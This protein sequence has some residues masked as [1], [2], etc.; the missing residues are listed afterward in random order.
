MKFEVKWGDIYQ[1]VDA[2]NQY[3]ACMELVRDAAKNNEPIQID[4]FTVMPL[5]ADYPE[6]MEVSLATILSV[7]LLIQ[8]DDEQEERSDGF[9]IPK[10]A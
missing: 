2:G 9:V 3:K 10:L 6:P 1:I 5:E 4:M 8:P 7:M